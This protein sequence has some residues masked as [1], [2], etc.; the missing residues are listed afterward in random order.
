MF[1]VFYVQRL[2]SAMIVGPAV[3]SFYCPGVV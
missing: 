1:T 3:W 2:R